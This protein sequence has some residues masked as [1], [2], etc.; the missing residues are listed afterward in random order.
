MVKKLKY[1]KIE[2]VDRVGALMLVNFLDEEGNMY[3]WAPKWNEVEQVFLKQI[4]VE[5]FNK[6]ESAWLNKFA[7]TAQNVVEGAQKIESAYKSYGNLLR[8]QNARLV[9]NTSD[10]EQEFIPAFD[11]TIDFLDHWL[12]RYV[13]VFVINDIVIRLRYFHENESKE[14]ITEEY[15]SPEISF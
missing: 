14:N 1:S 8:C 6:P 7:K 3:N 13:E 15:P 11:V 4:N 9:I 12:D 2:C 5:R 10:G